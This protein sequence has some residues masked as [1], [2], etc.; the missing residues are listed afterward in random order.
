M[1]IKRLNADDCEVYRNAIVRYIYE[2]KNH[3]AYAAPFSFDDAEKKYGELKMYLN[4]GQAMVTGAIQCEKLVGFCWAYRYPF[5][6]D[7]N[8]IYVS[9]L[10]VDSAHRN[11]GIGNMLLSETEKA[12][13]ENG[14][15]A[16]FLHT[17]AFNEGARR[18]YQRMG[19]R[20][21]RIQL[22]KTITTQKSSENPAG[23]GIKS[24]LHS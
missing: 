3:A 17:E 12:A 2:S 1:L 20:E 8:R 23:G 22:R 24:V 4:N 9:I 18:F 15:D 7:K 11:R 14:M 5:R 16:V 10:H 6:D 21:E 19:Y 13:A